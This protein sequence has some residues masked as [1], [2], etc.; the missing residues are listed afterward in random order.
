LSRSREREVA[1]GR[2]FAVTCHPTKP[3]TLFELPPRVLDPAL[4]D[5]A[6]VLG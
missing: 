6:Q 1:L 2:R 5:P 3:T 4:I